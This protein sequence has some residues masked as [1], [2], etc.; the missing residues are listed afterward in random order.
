MR[1]F[2]GLSRACRASRWVLGSVAVG[3][4]ALSVPT[5]RADIINISINDPSPALSGFTG[6]YANLNI[7]LTSPTT[8]TITFSS[9]INGGYT[10]LM[11]GQGAADLNV[12]GT[13]TLGPVSLS[14][15]IA[16]FNT[17][18]F[19]SDKPGNVGGWGNLN[20]AL[21]LFDGFTHAATL[22]SFTLT[23]TSGTWASAS[24]VLTENAQGIDVAVHAFA[25][26]NPCNS[27]EG[28]ATTGFAATGG[29]NNSVPEAPTLALLALGLVGLGFSRRKKA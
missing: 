12:N 22:I 8:A 17:P 24:N 29:T 6:P 18:T 28:A 20:L 1:P 7:N 21:D 14:N 26:L 4:I 15:G 5:A 23:D 9:L 2:S 11:G 25:C 19:V 3:L 13:Y 27:T 10:Y 16:G